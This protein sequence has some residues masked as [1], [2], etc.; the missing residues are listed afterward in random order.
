MCQGN[1]DRWS[2]VRVGWD[3]YIYFYAQQCGWIILFEEKSSHKSR[4]IMGS[5][6]DRMGGFG[7]R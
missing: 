7:V 5:P 3:I 2:V 6:F 4:K 1:G